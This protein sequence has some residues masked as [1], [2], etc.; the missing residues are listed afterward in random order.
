MIVHE[1]ATN[2]GKYGAPSNAYG[3]VEVSWKVYEPE[4]AKQRLSMSWIESG[5]PPVCAPARRGF[6]STVVESMA[7]MGLSADVQLD[8]ASSGLQWWLDC[9]GENAL[10]VIK[11]PIVRR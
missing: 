4:P 1:L 2:A 5:G 3:Q 11:G 10:E 8:Y 9:P 7:Q 6:G